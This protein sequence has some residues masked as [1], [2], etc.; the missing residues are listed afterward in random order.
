MGAIYRAAARV[1]VW[2]GPEAEGSGRAVDLLAEM[3]ALV[4][5]DP[6]LGLEPAEAAPEE[7]RSMSTSMAHI[8]AR[9]PYGEAD[10]TALYRLWCRPWFERLWVRQEIL[11]ASA[12]VVVCG[13][14]VLPWETFR[15][16]CTCAALKRP[17][18]DYPLYQQ[19]IDQ[20]AVLV[21]LLESGPRLNVI[22]ISWHYSRLKCADPRDRVYGL[23]ALL[24]AGD[25]GDRG[26]IR[27]DYSKTKRE[28]YG[29][30]V[31]WHM[32]RLRGVDF[33]TQCRLLESWD[34]PSWVPDWSGLQDN[35][36]PAPLEAIIVL[37]C[38]H[39]YCT[40]SVPRDGQ[41]SVVGVH[42]DKVQQLHEV[43]K[44]L[45]TL[46]DVANS[47]RTAFRG[48]F[49]S[50]SPLDDYISGGSLLEAFTRTLYRDYSADN[51]PKSAPTLGLPLSSYVDLISG[52]LNEP[53]T[54]PEVTTPELDQAYGTVKLVL[55]AARPFRTRQGYIGVA[56]A[57]ARVGDS[58]CSIAGCH[59]NLVLRPLEGHGGSYA[60]VGPCYTCGVS[61]G[62]AFLGPL[63]TGTVISPDWHPESATIS[64]LFLDRAAGTVSCLD[65]RLEEWPLDHA[66]YREE[67][68][69]GGLYFVHVDEEYLRARGVDAQTFTLV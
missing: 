9:L 38:S 65:P 39:L 37:A 44:S 31:T 42:I 34:G 20:G 11:L 68:E 33:L 36:E 12:A 30:L 27:P 54:L 22:T 18:D 53:D 28:V 46:A 16:G 35:R 23:L 13:G 14:R 8:G 59:T 66:R 26:G 24:G 10:L 57:Q 7:L 3:A 4:R 40:P 58:V 63:P 2:L 61:L 62:E 1:V 41:L 45:V 32:G 15:L 5:Y 29:D 56:P 51:T 19:Y 48:L 21:G 6:N 52:L 60:V 67:A 25:D 43:P 64:I 47:V 50:R 17:R 55:A 69:G 49:G